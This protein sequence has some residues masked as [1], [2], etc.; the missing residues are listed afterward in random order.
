M[1]SA[2]TQQ[3]KEF[4]EEWQSVTESQIWVIRLDSRGDDRYEAIEGAR[5]FYIS[6]EERLITQ[7]R[8]YDD[9]MDPFVNGS[10][11]PLSTPESISIATNPNALSD[12]D[13][14]RLLR[15]TQ[16]V[17]DAQMVAITSAA[18]LRR[19]VET[20]EKMVEEDVDISMKRFRFI[21]ERLDEVAP[22]RR[23]IVDPDRASFGKPGETTM[24]PAPARRG[25]GIS[26]TAAR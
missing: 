9:T 8:I 3:D 16:Q 23:Q 4:Q 18:T 12:E 7:E 6:T 26:M 22:S 13:I 5:T 15:S 10:F 2:I 21:Q 24:G 25:T 11:R 20:A 17:W 1:R 14:R 19:M